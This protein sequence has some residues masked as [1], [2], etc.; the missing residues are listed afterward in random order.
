MSNS[1]NTNEFLDL[2]TVVPDLLSQY[3]KY[4]QEAEKKAGWKPEP[5]PAATKSNGGSLAAPSLAAAKP[6]SF[7]AP[8]PQTSAPAAP[9]ATPK[10]SSD[11]VNKIVADVL[12]ED[13][14][15]EEDK[16]DDKKEEK[17]DETPKFSFGSKPA[18]GGLFSFAPSGP[19]AAT[20]PE[21]KKFTSTSSEPPAKLGK[22]GPDGTT[23]Q[24]PF[25]G[26]KGSPSA[27]PASKGFSFGAPSTSSPSFSFGASGSPTK[28]GTSSSAP[29]FSFGA[30]PSKADEAGKSAPSFSFG[31]TSTPSGD[32]G[33][34]KPAFSFGTTSAQPAAGAAKPF[35]FGSSAPSSSGFS[36]GAA[37]SSSSTP[38]TT[39]PAPA[40][41][42]ST[43]PAPTEGEAQDAEPSK[44][45]AEAI[46]EGEED[47]ETV[48]EQRG[49]LHKLED[50]KYTVVGLGQFKLKH[51]TKTDKRRLLMRAD[52]SGK[53]VLVSTSLHIVYI[54]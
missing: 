35:S 17:K 34:S 37:A 21:S 31:S 4:L 44:N 51:N 16:N 54:S 10:K 40:T 26:A 46:G 3:E 30:S 53:V 1:L 48:K 6:P 39:T 36:F 25:G 22:F 12:A 18:S 19:L 45:L 15:M 8:A 52:G 2:T 50:G 33:T 20:T 42:S 24:L 43:T 38:A 23:P 27:A 5:V 49:K 32:S 28:E 11:A 7:S 41:S 9:A 13:D 14:K 29:S 47:E